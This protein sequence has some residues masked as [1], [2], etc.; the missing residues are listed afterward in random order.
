MGLCLKKNN[1]LKKKNNLCSLRTEFYEGKNDQA[2]KLNLSG[3]TKASPYLF[4]LLSSQRPSSLLKHP[5]HY[6]SST[7]LTQSEEDGW[8]SN[9]QH[10][11][12]ASSF[13]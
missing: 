11:S 4:T 2:A 7:R 9:I 8:A 5:G 6:L 13:T 12:P 3:D 10:R 1:K